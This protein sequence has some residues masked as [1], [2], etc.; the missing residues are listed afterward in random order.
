MTGITTYLSILTLNVNRLN[1]P[2]KDTVWQTELKGRSNNHLLMGD[3]SHLQKQALIWGERL[4]ED[5]PSQWPLKTG[6]SSN[7]YI[8][9]TYIDQ[10]R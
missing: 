2:I 1:S 3:P 6:R 10:T 4:A 9:Q 8:A 5:L 7:T